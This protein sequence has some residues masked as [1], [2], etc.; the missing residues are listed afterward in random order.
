[1]FTL[2]Q[3]MLKVSF[4]IKD[5]KESEGTPSFPEDFLDQYDWSQEVYRGGVSLYDSQNTPVKYSYDKRPDLRVG[6][7]WGVQVKEGIHRPFLVC[8]LLGQS[9]GYPEGT[10]S[11]LPIL[12]EDEATLYPEEIREEFRI[13]EAWDQDGCTWFNSVVPWSIFAIERRLR[14]YLGSIPR[15]EAIRLDQLAG[16]TPVH[17]VHRN[18]IPVLTAQEAWT[19]GWKE[20]MT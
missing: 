7:V 17:K 20:A 14:A 13:S 8:E 3:E 11:V 9:A 4:G 16:L 15:E 1:M 19:S 2:T 5:I 12:S 18:T 6:Q 10:I